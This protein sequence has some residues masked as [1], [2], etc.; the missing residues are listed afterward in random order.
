MA[1]A[2]LIKPVPHITGA[3]GL[4]E[5]GLKQVLQDRSLIL[6]ACRVAELDTADDTLRVR[7][8]GRTVEVL[9]VDLSRGT[10]QCRVPAIGDIWFGLGA[11]SHVKSAKRVKARGLEEARQRAETAGTLSLTA[12]SFSVASSSVAAM[13]PEAL[14]ASLGNTALMAGPTPEQDRIKIRELE[15]TLHAGRQTL[16]ETTSSIEKLES[17]LLRERE[18]RAHATASFE[19]LKQ[20]IVSLTRENVRMMDKLHGRQS[21]HSPPQ[22]YNDLVRRM[23]DSN[24]HLVV[25]N[26][27]LMVTRGGLSIGETSHSALRERTE[28]SSAV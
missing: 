5:W 15:A 9:Q 26:Q 18:E 23:R 25:T 27:Q 28:S 2:D 1:A 11:L 4:E 16:K 10:A 22:E 7:S 12:S 3:G 14:L 8:A 20:K 13:E 21:L 24:Q 19:I 6:K 17:Q